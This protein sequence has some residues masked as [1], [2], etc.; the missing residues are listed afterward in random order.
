MPVTCR[1]CRTICVMRQPWQRPS[2]RHAPYSDFAAQVAVTSSLHDPLHDFAVNA[3][4]TV[5]VLEALRR[6]AP[7]TPL[8]FAHQQGVWPA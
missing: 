5:T 6:H 4:G 7:E 2:Q 3:Q 1:S 8:I